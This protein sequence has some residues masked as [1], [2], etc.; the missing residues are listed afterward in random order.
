MNP[1]PA[2]VPAP[3]YS[4]PA[5]VGWLLL[6]F[7]ASASAAFGSPDAWYAALHKPTWNPPPWIFGPV[8][9]LLYGMMAFAAWMVWKQGGW[10]QQRGPLGWFLVQWALNAA[11]TPLFFGLHL[12]GLA[13]LEMLLLWA[14]ITWTIRCFWTVKKAAAAL[15]VPYWL[16]VG[17][18]ALLNFTLWRLNP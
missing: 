3:R 17:F 12:P 4:I 10:R 8:W 11:W 1:F 2:P 16:W 18:A 13:F 9:S 6:C 7:S 14:A 5:L 15:L